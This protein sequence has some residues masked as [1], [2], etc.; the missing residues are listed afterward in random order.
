MAKWT[1]LTC[2]W[3]EAGWGVGAWGESEGLEVQDEGQGVRR[4]VVLG[5]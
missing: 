5:A 2:D 3:R 1:P 4:W